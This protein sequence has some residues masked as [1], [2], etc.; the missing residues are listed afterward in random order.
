MF[1]KT[2]LGPD[3]TVAETFTVQVQTQVPTHARITGP[4]QFPARHRAKCE[5][6]LLIREHRETRD[7]L[8][9]CLGHFEVSFCASCHLLMSFS[10]AATV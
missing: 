2:K 3:D 8:G 10:R 7:Y 1:A 5:T 4:D 9:H 6:S